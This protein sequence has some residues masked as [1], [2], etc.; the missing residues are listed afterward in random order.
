MLSLQEPRACLFV[1]PKY[2]HTLRSGSSVDLL[3]YS[4][5]CSCLDD[6]GSVMDIVVKIQ[7]RNCVS[8]HP[9]NRGAALLE[10]KLVL[11]QCFSIAGIVIII[12]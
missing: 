11:S 5:I 1:I 6:V 12:A 3:F 7:T 4:V 8:V 9:S 10:I 2:Y